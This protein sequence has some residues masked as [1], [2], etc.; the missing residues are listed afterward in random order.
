MYTIVDELDS[1]DLTMYYSHCLGV[2]KAYII[3][4]SLAWLYHIIGDSHRKQGVFF[5]LATLVDFFLFSYFNF[6]IMGHTDWQ[7]M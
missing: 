3:L 4:V 1:T 6:S 5:R 2:K 7:V